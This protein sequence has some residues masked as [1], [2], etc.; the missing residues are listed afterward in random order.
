MTLDRLVNLG[1]LALEGYVCWILTL[2]YFYDKKVYEQKRRR[3]KRTK[4]HVRL[5][6][7]DGQVRI[8]EKPDDV[9]VVIEQKD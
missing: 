7:E 3:I 4:D 9:N 8:L 1:M 6:V 2:E 5:T